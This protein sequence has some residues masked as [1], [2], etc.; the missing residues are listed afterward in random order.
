MLSANQTEWF[1]NQLYL[2]QKVMNQFDFWYAEIFK[3][4]LIK[5]A[6]S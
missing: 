6:F 5:S 3:L 2:K 4:N 1:L